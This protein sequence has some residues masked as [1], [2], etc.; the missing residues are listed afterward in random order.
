MKYNLSEIMHKAWKLYR[1]GTA[2]QR[3][4]HQ[5]SPDRRRGD[6]GSQHMGRVESRRVRSPAWCK[7]PFPSGSHPFQQGRRPD[8]PRVILWSVPSEAPERLKQTADPAEQE[9]PAGIYFEGRFLQ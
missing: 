4:A 7:G 6:R 1:K 8:L 9:K 3:P 5:R 2:H